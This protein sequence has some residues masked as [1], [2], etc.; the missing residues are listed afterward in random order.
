MSTKLKDEVLA[1]ILDD[2]SFGGAGGGAS[3]PGAVPKGTAGSAPLGED[4]VQSLD[5]GDHEERRGIK[6][7]GE[8]EERRATRVGVSCM[9]GARRAG[10]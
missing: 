3:R 8:H 9:P 7:H 5:T 1:E 2:C 4:T 6:T 10:A